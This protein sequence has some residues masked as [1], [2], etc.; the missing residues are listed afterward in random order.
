MSAVDKLV[1]YIHQ[2]KSEQLDKEGSKTS[3]DVKESLILEI[4]KTISNLDVSKLEYIL[5]FITKV[6]GSR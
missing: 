2:L 4:N 1:A 6:F 3:A 5:T